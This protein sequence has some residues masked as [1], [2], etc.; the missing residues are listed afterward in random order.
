MK[1][2][3]KTD[4]QLMVTRIIKTEQGSKLCVPCFRQ[5]NEQ[6]EKE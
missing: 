5:T 3:S 6:K 4:E 1:T 2:S